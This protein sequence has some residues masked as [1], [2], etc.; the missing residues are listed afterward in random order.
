MRTKDERKTM[1]NII[2][3]RPILLTDIT[4]IAILHVQSFPDY[5]LSHLGQSFLERYYREFVDSQNSYGFVAEDGTELVGLVVGVTH[6][7]VF[8]KRFYKRNFF[9]LLLIVGKRLLVERPVGH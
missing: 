8:Y 1:E 7:D 3:V 9:A 2:Q 5:F 4:N 6:G